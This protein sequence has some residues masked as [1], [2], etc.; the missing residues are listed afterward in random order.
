MLRAFFAGTPHFSVPF[1][2]ALASKHKVVGILTAE[3]KPSGRGKNTV[4]SAV[5]VKAIELGLRIFQPK[6]IDSLFIEK[7]TKLNPDILVVVAIGTIFKREFLKVFPQS[8]INVH[9][10][11]LPRHRGVSPISATILAGDCE[12]GVSV[13][14]L[15]MKVDTGAI[16]AQKRIRL[17]GHETTSSLTQLLSQ[18]GVEL[19]IQVLDGIERG[20]VK[21]IKQVERNATYCG[22]IHKK[23][24]LINWHESAEIISRKIRAYNMWPKTYTSLKGKTLYL[25]KGGRYPMPVSIENRR[26][27]K[28]GTILGVDDKY[29]ILILCGSGILYVQE[30]Q[31]QY[32]KRI[33]WGAF[34]NGYPDHIG[35]VLGYES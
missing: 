17:N 26:R 13:Q 2:E 27:Y 8:G 19:L 22:F 16:I 32:K 5:K 31:L 35:A 28:N 20:Q 4:P 18:I 10:S 29:G 3:D 24:G 15:A 1:L 34:L 11:L 12:A 14:K 21:E 25:L 33:Q 30:L 6:E 23:D 9:P 7:I